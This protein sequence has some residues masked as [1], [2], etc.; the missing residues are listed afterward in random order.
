MNKLMN[1]ILSK[2]PVF[3]KNEKCCGNPSDVL[4][5]L[6][7]SYKDILDAKER[8]ER[9][10]PLVAGLFPETEDGIIESP[11]V[12]LSRLQKTM[13]PSMKGK[14]FAKLD[15]HLEVAG[16]IKARGGIYEVMKVTEDL[17]FSNN[18]L[19]TDDDYT[20]I[21]D[22]DIKEFLS[23]YS[24]SVASTGNLGLSIGIMSAVLGYNARVHMS[25]DAK[26]WKK[27]RLTDKGV[28]VIEHEGDF[29]Y[30][31]A[32]AREEADGNDRMHFVDDE[33]SVN[34]F[35][36]YSV[37]ALRI[38]KDF[39]KL[40]IIPSEEKPLYLYLPCGVGGAP[41]GITFGFKHVFGKNVKC[42][43]AEPVSSPSMLLSVLTGKY[44]E[45]NVNDYGLDNKTDLDGLAVASP[46]DFVSP[47]MEGLCDG[48]YTVTD[49]DMFKMLYLLKLNEGI[50]IE[51]S[52]AAG[53]PGPNMT[54][55]E[56]VRGIHI[57]WTTG[58]LFVPDRIYD[59]M[60]SR[61]MLIHENSRH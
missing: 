3:L 25:R 54:G 48:F 53:L 46:S 47:M 57:A 15:S 23:G 33:R 12:R 43:F 21:M 58:G 34:L 13:Y 18:M 27:D 19:K 51:P 59:K 14:L 61:G 35:L 45:L 41:G 17:L 56:K 37:A 49:E 26:Q 31:V 55:N 40:G 7:I 10:S 22:K 11:F 44:G 20:K 4:N 2:K 16:S 36:G 32:K 6:N 50:K 29:T 30:A 52:A 9:F 60:Y 24:I 38:K 5:K 28:T 42:Y 1:D 8:M 39:E